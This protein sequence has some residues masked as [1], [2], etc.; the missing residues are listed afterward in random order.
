MFDNLERVHRPLLE[1][2]EALSDTLDE[3]PKTDEL[4]LYRVLARHLYGDSSNFEIV[5]DATIDH[6]LRV[7][8]N[9]KHP[10]H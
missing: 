4:S 10:P 1:W 7:W 5:L 2:R 6:L 8:V 3:D 9:S